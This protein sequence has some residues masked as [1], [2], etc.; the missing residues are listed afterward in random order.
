MKELYNTKYLIT[1]TAYQLFDYYSIKLTVLDDSRTKTTTYNL[2]DDKNSY[3]DFG[4]PTIVTSRFHECLAE[5]NPFYSRGK[6]DSEHLFESPAKY[7]GDKSF[8]DLNI[9]KK[10]VYYIKYYNHTIFDIDLRPISLPILFDYIG[11]PF[12]SKHHNLTAMLPY[13]KSHPWVLNG[14]DLEIKKIPYYSNESGKE[15]YICTDGRQ[16]GIYIKIPQDLYEELHKK[17]SNN[18][19]DIIGNGKGY[20]KCPVDLLGLNQFFKR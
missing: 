10:D 2:S 9:N 18:L 19:K 15:T 12:N 14:A 17:H 20:D 11:S 8:K 6:Y 13:L 16:D 4:V 7:F 1:E 3:D 5:E